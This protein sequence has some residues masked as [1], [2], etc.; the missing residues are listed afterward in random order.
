MASDILIVDDE[1]DIRE[2]VAGILS[3]EGH[4]SDSS[5][6]MSV[7]KSARGSAPQQQEGDSWRNAQ[8]EHD[9]EGTAFQVPLLPARNSCIVSSVCAWRPP[10][11]APWPFCSPLLISHAQIKQHPRHHRRSAAGCRK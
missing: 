8:N 9:E 7:S 4:E 10:F 5:A 11:S 2:L 3:D 1:E 6:A